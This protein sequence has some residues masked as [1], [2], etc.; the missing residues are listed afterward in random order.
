VLRPPS[1]QQQDAA[2]SYT[3]NSKQPTTMISWSTAAVNLPLLSFRCCCL[4]KPAQASHPIGIKDFE[5]SASSVSITRAFELLRWVPTNESS[6]WIWR[7]FKTQGIPQQ[8]RKI[9]LQPMMQSKKRNFCSS[10]AKEG[11]CRFLQ[12]QSFFAEFPFSFFRCEKLGIRLQW[13]LKTTLH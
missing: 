8:F 12:L 13:P 3:V 1:P 2:V 6:L 4:P 5:L 11:W 10:S 9:I 7:W